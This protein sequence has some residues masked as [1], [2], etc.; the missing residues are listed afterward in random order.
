MKRLVLLSAI[1]ISAVGCAQ[2]PRIN[3]EPAITRSTE[4]DCSSLFPRG[5]WQLLHTIEA[6]VPGGKKHMLTGVSVLSSR[7]RSINWALMTTEGFVLFSGRY[8]GTLTIDRALPPFDRPGFAQGLMDDL[9]A[10][11][12]APQAPLIMSGCLKSGAHVCRYA[13]PE[14]TSDIVKAQDGTWTIQQYSPHQR[15][16]RSIRADRIAP[17]E[18]SLLARHLVVKEHGIL[19]YQLELT[20]IEAVPLDDPT[21]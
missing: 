16:V 17:F 6:M 18:N 10:L 12:F 21:P 7:N 13:S 20:L 3:P 19:G 4:R 2:L 1:L 11:F 15:L 8:D 9:M 14:M 5:R